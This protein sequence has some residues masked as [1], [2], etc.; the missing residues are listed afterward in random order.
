MNNRPRP[1]NAAWDQRYVDGDMPW[2]TGS[3]DQHLVD[4]ITSKR[5]MAPASVLEIGCGTGT[6]A[7][8]LAE[9][10]FEVLAT[11][12][13]PTAIERASGAVQHE[14]LRFQV[15]DFLVEDPPGA[16]FDFVFDR[17][18]FHIFDKPEV[19]AR[20]AARVA[21]LLAPGGRWLSLIGSTE[22]APRDRGPPRRSATEILAAI[23]P[24]MELLDLR[25]TQFFADPENPA[26]A[27]ICLARKRRMPAQPSTVWAD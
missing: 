12:V 13:S 27:W 15:L 17:G 14:S 23:E 18:V 21:E 19:Q 22:G 5:I 11:D 9:Q 2:D 16:P 10:G 25:S 6:N 8:W 3:P 1:T 26:L 4:L 7:L 24:S 20:F